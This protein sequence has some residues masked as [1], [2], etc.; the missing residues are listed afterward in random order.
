MAGVYQVRPVQGV[1]VRGFLR[2]SRDN[3][4]MFRQLKIIIS[5]SLIRLILAMS[6][7]LVLLAILLH[8]IAGSGSEAN[9]VMVYQALKGIST[10]VFSLYVLIV[11]ANMVLRALRYHLI[12]PAT[13]GQHR[14]AFWPLFVVTGVRN[15][16]VDLLPARLGE[17]IFVMMLKKGCGV[18]IPAGLAT[19]ALSLLLDIFILVPVLLAVGLLPLATPALQQG[20]LPA[21]LVLGAIWIVGAVVLWPG[22]RL[23][24]R[25]AQTRTR[26]DGIMARPTRFLLALSEA[27]TRCRQGRI[28]SRALLLTFAIRV[29]KYGGLYLLFDAV[30]ASP[31][32]VAVG[33]DFIDVLVALIASEAGASLPVPTLMSFGTYE[34]GGAVA[35]VLLGYP[36]AAA[37]IALLS[38][39]IASQ[40][41][42]YSV[43]CACL[44]LFFLTRMGN[45]NVG[46][47]ASPRSV[48]RWTRWRA[49]LVFIGLLTTAGLSLYQLDRIRIAQSQVA[50]PTG[51]PLTIATDGAKAVAAI[52]GVSGWVVW[53]SN[54]FGNHDILKMN[55]TDRSISRLTRHPHAESFPRIS[56]NG[57]K[58]VFAR[59]REPWVSLRNLVPWDVYLLDLDSGHER[60]LAEFANAPTWSADG[61]HVYFQRR[62]SEFVKLDLA[63]GE[64]HVLFRA[65]MGNI[66]AGVELRTPSLSPVSGRLASTWRGARRMMAIVNVDGTV[67]PV[68]EGC[69]LAWAPQDTFIYWV[70]HGGLMQNRLY[71][72]L[73]GAGSPVPWLDLPPPYS[74]EYFPKLSKDGRYLVLGASAGGHEHDVADYEIFLWPAGMSADRA[75]RLTFHSGNDNWPDIFLE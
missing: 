65:G 49:P 15:M 2:A 33:A 48:G 23:L 73:P 62:G 63:N 6:L 74:H 39:H 7:S 16:V 12:L 59:S 28:L 14:V 75:V 22:L 60:L 24:A 3:V 40:V 11:G 53:S 56:P 35:L 25:W 42:D 69:Q 38:V 44:S 66:P 46:G 51:R 57:Q 5:Q 21:A 8:L 34:A 37:V 54:R 32:L 4:L 52:T 31:G 61:G 18:S 45:L 20:S 19:L 41:L 17:L 30:V 71:R 43:G 55:L 70:D 29:L 47:V 13:T 36:L 67:Q 64:E 27:L 10:K 50:P 72:Q 68:G 1:I 9:L 58:I 26:P